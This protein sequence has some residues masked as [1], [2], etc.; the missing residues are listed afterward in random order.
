M[1][2]RSAMSVLPIAELP[3]LQP[4]PDL[5]AEDVLDG[6]TRPF[7]ELPPKHLYDARG[8]ELFER[9]TDLTECYPT[10]TELAMLEASAPE[11]VAVTGVGELVELGS[12]SASKSR[13]LLG[14]GTLRRYVPF[15]VSEPSV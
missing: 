7:K 1:T 13:I 3:Q 8:S 15:E 9:I 6:L 12:G 5:L 4:A 10:R 11:I 14:A 2:D